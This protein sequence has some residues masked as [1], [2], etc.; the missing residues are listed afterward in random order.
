MNVLS[1]SPSLRQNYWKKSSAVVETSTSQTAVMSQS[2]HA[3]R[4]V[5]FG[6]QP[7][8]SL[9]EG[10]ILPIYFQMR[11]KYAAL[12][13]RG[14][15]HLRP[16]IENYSQTLLKRV[17]AEA[18][19]RYQSDSTF[20]AE[21]HY[22]TIPLVMHQSLW[23]YTQAGDEE[24]QRYTQLGLYVLNKVQSL[25]SQHSPQASSVAK[26]QSAVHQSVTSK[27][28]SPETMNAN[29]LIEG[30]LQH[31]ETLSDTNRSFVQR[32]QEYHAQMLVKKVMDES[33][34]EFAQLGMGSNRNPYSHLPE[35]VQL[36]LQEVVTPLALYDSF[37][38]PKHR[39][40]YTPNHPF[41]TRYQE[42]HADAE[43]CV[44]DVLTD[45]LQKLNA[46]PRKG[47]T[48]FPPSQPSSGIHT[49]PGSA[50]FSTSTTHSQ[51]PGQYPPSAAKSGATSRTTQLPFENNPNY[52]G[53]R[54]GSPSSSQYPPTSNPSPSHVN[55]TGLPPVPPA[56]AS[57]PPPAP[58]KTQPPYV[59]PPDTLLG[60]DGYGSKVN[61]AT[62]GTF[63]PPPPPTDGGAMM[64]TPQA[65]EADEG[66]GNEQVPAWLLG[67][68]LLLAFGLGAEPVL[69][70]LTHRPS[71]GQG[72]NP[73][74]QVQ[75]PAS[76]NPSSGTGQQ[77]ASP[78]QRL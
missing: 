36:D 3:D 41:N 74:A 9:D 28:L 62:G 26:A 30:L 10:K 8:Y 55:G 40:E 24:K 29:E 20:R 25:A 35:D 65:Q 11:E 42:V 16:Y 34:D 51:F 2:L 4:F 1:L 60:Y 52:Q 58:R 14:K 69:K 77:Q 61:R 76:P 48:H 43:S 5:R 70:W 73:P 23:P 68:L 53:N 72:G 75:P 13:V 33:P 32:W 38:T 19:N 45:Y 71:N 47:H 56:V 78:D 12:D 50:A 17:G 46:P 44:Y 57:P 54:T 18:L 59:Q 27:P 22:L 67:P 63:F 66:E 6:A 37:W 49:P 7:D 31:Y 15:E 39:H 21:V 64:H